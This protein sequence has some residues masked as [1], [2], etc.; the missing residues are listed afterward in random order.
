MRNPIGTHV[1]V[2]NPQDNGGESLC[3]VT[4]FLD[5]GDGEIVVN[6][7][8]SL[9]SYCNSA[10]FT[11]GSAQFLPDQLRELANQLDV[12]LLEKK[13]AAAAGRAAQGL[14]QA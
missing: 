13:A 11:L 10:S 2:F 5:N 6:Q 7:E 14:P 12:A 4:K 3:L 9:Q 8:L 1:F